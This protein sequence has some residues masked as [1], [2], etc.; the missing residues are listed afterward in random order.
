MV[1]LADISLNDFFEDVSQPLGA[2]FQT[3]NLSS[4]V[5]NSPHQSPR[6]LDDIREENKRLL[7]ENKKLRA[8]CEELEACRKVYQQ[9]QKM[10]TL[11]QATHLHY[12]LTH[13]NCT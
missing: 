3:G 10:E 5:N 8:E 12:H 13:L 2:D 1:C 6:N 7:E 11:K 4:S 9:K